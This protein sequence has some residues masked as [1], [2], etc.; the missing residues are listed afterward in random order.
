MLNNVKSQLNIFIAGPMGDEP[1]PTGSAGQFESL[2]SGGSS[3]QPYSDTILSNNSYQA[4]FTSDSIQATSRSKYLLNA[5]LSFWS[6]QGDTGAT[7]D[8]ALYT[9]T[10]G[11]RDTSYPDIITN[12][13]NIVSG[14]NDIGA[15]LLLTN[16]ASYLSVVQNF[17]IGN[18]IVLKGQYVDTPLSNGNYYYKLFIGNPTAISHPI[19]NINCMLS[20]VSVNP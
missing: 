13:I 2:E 8:T 20:V 10:I 14:S 18:N 1:G 12:Y 15:S 17:N 5:N 4:V 3:Y 6:E 16:P 11:R 19:K 7:G 9:M